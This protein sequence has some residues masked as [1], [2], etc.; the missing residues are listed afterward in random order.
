MHVFIWSK[1][2]LTAVIIHITSLLWT[3]P[4]AQNQKTTHWF[5]F[6][7]LQQMLVTFYRMGMLV[8]VCFLSVALQYYNVINSVI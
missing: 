8:L 5:G 1:V 6:L 7:Q 2:R 4:L 3:I